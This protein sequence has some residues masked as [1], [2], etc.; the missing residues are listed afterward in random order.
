MS[1]SKLPLR[2]LLERGSCTEGF[3]HGFKVVR[4]KKKLKKK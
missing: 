4:H 1:Q 2:P 3:Q